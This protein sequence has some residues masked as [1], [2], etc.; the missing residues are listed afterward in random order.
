MSQ[1]RV[2]HPTDWYI[3]VQGVTHKRGDVELQ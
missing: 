1:L 3:I 2:M